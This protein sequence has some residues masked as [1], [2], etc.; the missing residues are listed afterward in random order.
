[1]QATPRLNKLDEIVLGVIAPKREMAR[2]ED[3]RLV[4]IEL[5]SQDEID[6][7]AVTG[8]FSK[9]SMPYE[10]VEIEPLREALG[11][12]RSRST[13]FVRTVRVSQPLQTTW[14]D[15]TEDAL[16]QIGEPEAVDQKDSWAWLL[17]SIAAGGAAVIGMFLAFG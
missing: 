3:D 17:I 13:T 2:P 7:C 5:V 10:R 12:R 16:T 8:R 14:F 4:A 9:L 6:D 1:M 11:S 15:T